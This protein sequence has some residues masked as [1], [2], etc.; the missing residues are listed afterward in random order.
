MPNTQPKALALF[1]ASDGTAAVDMSVSLVT[2]AVPTT[3]G[4]YASFTAIT[5]AGPS[6]DWSAED[7][8]VF[9]PGALTAG[10]DAFPAGMMSSSAAQPAG[11][12]ATTRLCAFCT[13]SY[14]RYK[15]TPSD[16]GSGILPTA[17]WAGRGVL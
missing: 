12:G 13:G 2:E 7:S 17:V 1:K 10:W 6:G 14:R 11:S 15:W 9:N 8:D 16:G 4:T 3:P 5:P